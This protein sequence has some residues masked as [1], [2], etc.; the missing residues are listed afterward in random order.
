MRRAFFKTAEHPGTAI[1]VRQ[2]RKDMPSGSDMQTVNT[3][4]F[5]FGGVL[6]DEG[7]R[8]G[9]AAI[10]R[11]SGLVEEDVIL[12]GHELVLRTG[13]VTGRAGERHWWDTLRGEARVRGTDEVLRR[14]ILERFTLRPEMLGLVEQLNNRGFTVGILSDQT[15]WLDELD[16]R[17]GLYGRF[18]YIFNSFHMG[19]SKNDASHF[20]DVLRLLNRK[21]QEVLF[22][23]DNTGHVARAVEGGWKAILYRDLNGFLQELCGKL[24]PEL[25]TSSIKR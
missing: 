25:P 11:M 14:E 4:L 21:G 12:R 8:N 16:D 3:V 23:D 6:A 20:D 17:F 22:I 5:D 1:R 15:N 9:L 13:Y 24:P 2:E 19:K 10:G 7:F 18:D